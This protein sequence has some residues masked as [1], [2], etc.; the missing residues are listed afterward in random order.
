MA[1]LQSLLESLRLVPDGAG[2]YRAANA[3]GTNSVV[4]GGQLLAQSIV[5]AL[6]SHDG[7][8][9][10]TLHTVFARAAVPQHGLTIDVEEMHRGRAFASATV[11]ISQDD[12]MCTRSLVLL[13][14]DDEEVIRHADPAPPTS[15]PD[16]DASDEGWIVRVVDDVDLRDP[17][18]VGPADLGVWTRFVGAPDDPTVDTALVAYATD[19]F[20]I[21]TAMRPHRGVGQSMAHVTLSTGVISHTFTLH[22]PIRAGEWFLLS[23]HSPYAGHGRSYG[24]GD[25]FQ[26]GRLVGSFVQDSMIRPMGGGRL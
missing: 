20:L 1:E 16:P 23:H 21:G 5:A 2:R 4:F 8:R 6:A 25:V 26:R 10:K 9:L 17:Q 15:V 24:R 14:S 3:E 7:K 11:T 12:R 19:P 22:E 13:T 18:A